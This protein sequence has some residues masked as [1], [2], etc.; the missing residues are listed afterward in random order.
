MTTVSVAAYA[1]LSGGALLALVR[2][3]R[4]P[5]LLD[6]ALAT[7]TLLAIVAGGVAVHAALAREAAFVPVL[8]VVALLGF[9]GTVAVARFVG[10]MLRHSRDDGSDVGLPVAAERGSA[11][12]PTE[13]EQR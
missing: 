13:E 3:A 9:L 2:I 12:P 10:G 1:L 8:V 11:G 5:S 7:E 4:G 6:R